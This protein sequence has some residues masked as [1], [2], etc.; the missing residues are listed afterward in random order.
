MTA[1]T[2]WAVKSMWD[3]TNKRLC[4][5]DHES[6]LTH[7]EHPMP[8]HLFFGRVHTLYCTVHERQSAVHDRIER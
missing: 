6:S 1:W 2:K 3:K 5:I 7:L 4:G 8:G